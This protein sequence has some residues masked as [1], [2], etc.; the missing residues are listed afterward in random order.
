VADDNPLIE[1]HPTEY[2]NDPYVIAQM[3]VWWRLILQSKSILLVKYVRIVLGQ[4]FTVEL[5]TIGF[6][7]M[8]L[9]V[10]KGRAIIA[11]P[12][13]A[14]IQQD[15]AHVETR[16]RR[17]YWSQPCAYIVTEYGVAG[18]IREVNPSESTGVDQHSS[19]KIPRRSN[20]QATELHYL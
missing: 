16:R 18:F 7:L 13:T 14:G 15:S 12:S 8:A 1:L 2:I 11:L 9:R 3:N 6:Y 17:C 4:D 10:R 19:P 20:P 5:E